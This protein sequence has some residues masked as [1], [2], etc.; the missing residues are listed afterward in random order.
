MSDVFNL[1][2]GEL[3]DERPE[4]AG[5]RWR[6][7]RLGPKLGAS[8]IGATLYELAPGERSFPYHYEYG[9]E[10]WL[11]CVAGTP[12]LRTPEG[13]RELRAGDVTAFPEGPAGAHQVHNTGVEPARV[14][15][16]STKGFPAIAVYPDS[17]KVG[18]WLQNDK[19]VIVVRRESNVDYWYRE[20]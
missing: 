3:E 1:N 15:I 4:P 20:V 16:W 17:D 19:D 6:A 8:M 11:L 9:A 14:L 2:D 5:F 7:T 10:E 18:V 13:E 12:T